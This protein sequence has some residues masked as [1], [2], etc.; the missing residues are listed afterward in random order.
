MQRSALCVHVTP[1][2]GE[3]VHTVEHREAA[4]EVLRGR[5][6]IGESLKRSRKT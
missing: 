6:G 4:L 5:Y 1:Q 3:L 2:L